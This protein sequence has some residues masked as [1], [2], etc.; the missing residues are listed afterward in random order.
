MLKLAYLCRRC[1]LE[2][3]LC[4]IV[5]LYYL[6]QSL[7][8][9]GFV[10]IECFAATLRCVVRDILEQFLHE[11]MESSGPYIFSFFVSDCS[12]SSD[13][14]EARGLKFYGDTF[15]VQQCLI[16]NWESIFGLN[17]DS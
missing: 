10:D 14:F 8:N 16:L 9:V 11:S 7:L 13:F 5:A 15:G 17:K 3:V 1:A 4:Q 6:A 2:D 12:K